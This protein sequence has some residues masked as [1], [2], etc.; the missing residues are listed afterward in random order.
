MEGDKTEAHKYSVKT[1]ENRKRSGR[2]KQS[3]FNES[4][5]WYILIQPYKQSLYILMIK[6][7]QLQDKIY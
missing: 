4:K 2:K 3:K 6:T 1:R 7:H 5:S